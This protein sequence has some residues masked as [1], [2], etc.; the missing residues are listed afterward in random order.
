MCTAKQFD[1]ALV[2]PAKVFDQ[3]HDIVVSDALT[4]AQKRELLKRWEVDE[5]LLSVATEENMGG[6]EPSRL[7]EVRA[8]ID[9]IDRVEKPDKIAA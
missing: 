8:A 1:E 6:G 9:L 5:Q 7:D 2:N 4:T 3:P